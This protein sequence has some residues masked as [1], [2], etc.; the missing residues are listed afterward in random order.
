MIFYKAIQTGI[1]LIIPK[2]IEDI[3]ND[4]TDSKPKQDRT[5]Y[6]KEQIKTI[7]Q[8]YNLWKE[9]PELYKNQADFTK[10]INEKFGTNKSIKTIITIGKANEKL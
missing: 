9:N 6:S 8:M 2:L 3:Y 4:L 10:V 7:I 1:S 5:K